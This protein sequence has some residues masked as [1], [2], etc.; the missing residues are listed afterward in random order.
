MTDPRHDLGGGALRIRDVVAMQHFG[1]EVVAGADGLDRRIEWT[2][3]SELEDPGPWLEGGE[4]LIVNGFGV[5]EDGAAQ[6][7]YIRRLSRH[8]AVALALGMR[9]PPVQQEMLDAADA[10]GLPLLRLPKE[11][12]FVAIS[13]VVANANQHAAQRRLVRHLQ[14]LDTL[15]LRDGVRVSGR[16]RFA[17]L[18]DISGY[19]LA[20]LST[21]GHPVLA[22]WPW[23]PED[24]DV[25]ALVVDGEDRIVIDGGYALPL[26]VGHR[27]AAF[28]I[29]L[30][31]PD[32]Q[33]AGISALQHIAT[34]AT[35]E[36]VEAYRQR[37]ARRRGGAESL[38]ELLAGR[39]TAETA[40]SRLETEGF[41]QTGPLVLA[42]FRAPDG[43]LDDDELH[44]WLDDRSIPHLMLRQDELYV[45]LADSGG[46]FDDLVHELDV[47]VGVSAPIADVVRIAT[48][49]RE[50]LWSLASAGGV[51]SHHVVRFSA[52]DGSA[53]WFPAD[54]ETLGLMV[55]ATLGPI[56]EYDAANNSEL[57]HSL[58]TFFRNRR[59]LRATAKEL[60]VHEHTLA[61]RLKRI[62]SLTNRDLNEVQDTSE[63]WLALKALPVVRGSD[64]G[65][66]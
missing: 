60:F 43:V 50:A 54:I 39:L 2:H 36:V 4:M 51:T 17:E 29:A 34:V 8:R 61:Y 48:A 45:L 31:Q 6:A 46:R 55:Q 1:L 18:E 44:H 59:K 10:V 16:E 14:I 28:L 19:R 32:R 5:P 27:I 65:D 37:E 64:A 58:S 21:A 30:E 42:A 33:P 53:H 3:V 38:A 40:V 24:I 11:T 12:P 63:L 41:G 22:E 13:H 25:A 66:R 47:V 26:P 62:E 35:L 56:L 7:E 52:H 9:S 20:L 49:R 23:V 57:L 15:R